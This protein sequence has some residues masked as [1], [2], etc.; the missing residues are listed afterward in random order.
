MTW[1][2]NYII[3]ISIIATIHILLCF[4]FFF[5][6][7]S[8]VIWIITRPIVTRGWTIIM[9]AGGRVFVTFCSSMTCWIVIA[10]RIVLNI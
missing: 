1:H 2:V 5:G 6:I 7:I 9:L 3:P 4:Q 10:N 8:W